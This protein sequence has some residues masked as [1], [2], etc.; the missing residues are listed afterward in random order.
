ML[1]SKEVLEAG[2]VAKPIISKTGAITPPEKIAPI[3]HTQSERRTAGSALVRAWW[4]NL[5]A[6]RQPANPSPDP[7]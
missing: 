3:S 6:D 1:S 2:V 5:R 7:R 4:R